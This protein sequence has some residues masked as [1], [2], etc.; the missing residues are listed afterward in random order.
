ML[1]KK[2]GQALI[3]ITVT[4]MAIIG[5]MALVVD[6]GRA[7]I[8]HSRL[9]RAADAAVL[10]GV[11][12]LPDNDDSEARRIA[13]EAFDLNMNLAQTSSPSD[14]KVV[15]YQMTS[16]AGNP[17]NPQQVDRLLL[18]VDSTVNNQLAHFLGYPDWPIVAQAGARSGPIGRVE[19]WIP[20]GVEEGSIELY[21]H[22]RLGNTDHSLGSNSN[23]HKRMYVPLQNGNLRDEV[24]NT[25][26]NPISAGQT[27][28]IAMNANIQD[29]CD[30]IENR[31]RQKIGVA[32]CF[33]VDQ[34][35]P[36]TNGLNIIGPG[37]RNDWSY[38]DDPRLV[39]VPFVKQT[40]NNTVEIVG[41]GLFY[42]EYAHYDSQAVGTQEPL[43]EIV[44]F[45]VRTVMEGPVLD[46][47]DNYG[48]IGVEYIDFL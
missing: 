27:K 5:M 26:R 43:T 44:G 1:R 14:P 2:K 29:I 35:T 17:R 31:M 8:D 34:A 6:T 11:Q 28:N 19:H 3:V 21:E 12:E 24:A 22:Y 47:A 37:T 42:I 13:Q 39:Y 7:Y 33:N 48:V 4:L 25:I 32:G 20:I 46:D 45:F 15:N 23:G 40:A 18:T 10:A 38:G 36:N 30:G 9:Q 16:L 41:F